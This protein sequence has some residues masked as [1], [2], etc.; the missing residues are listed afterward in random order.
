MQRE[1]VS[2]RVRLFP[3]SP[4]T[5]YCARASTGRNIWTPT[6]RCTCRAQFAPISCFGGFVFSENP[7]RGLHISEFNKI[8][9]SQQWRPAASAVA[10][11][12]SSRH[13][14]GTNFCSTPC[15][16]HPFRSDSWNTEFQIRIFAATVAR[17]CIAR[18]VSTR[19]GVGTIFTPNPCNENLFRI[20]FTLPQISLREAS[21]FRISRNY[22]VCSGWLRPAGTIVRSVLP[23]DACDSGDDFHQSPCK[24]P[25]SL[26]YFR[27][28][29][30]PCRCGRFSPKSMQGL[31]TS[32]PISDSGHF[33]DS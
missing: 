13:A 24:E 30:A 12:L 23:R 28:L 14:V 8:E 2:Q 9:V 1:P 6:R 3:K 19:H 4:A 11:S 10:R 22:V 26:N 33:T 32:E 5:R 27:S 20:D 21:G 31:T 7:T 16:E 17:E 18:S 25:P 15:N 29:V